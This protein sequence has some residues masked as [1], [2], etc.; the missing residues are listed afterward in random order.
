M[1]EFCREVDRHMV[2][3]ANLQVVGVGPSGP[4]QTFNRGEAII[5]SHGIN[6]DISLCSGAYVS[7]T[8]PSGKLHNEAYQY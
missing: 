7:L 1:K 5:A 8:S 4:V 3:T 6:I 2:F